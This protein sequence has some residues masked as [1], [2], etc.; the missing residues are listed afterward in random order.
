MFFLLNN[1]V[2]RDTPVN[3]LFSTTEYSKSGPV[4][5]FERDRVANQWTVNFSSMNNAPIGNPFWSNPTLFFNHT[6][7]GIIM[8]SASRVDVIKNT[9]KHHDDRRVESTL[10]SEYNEMAVL[11][12]SRNEGGWWGEF[13]FYR[14]PHRVRPRRARRWR[15]TFHARSREALTSGF[16]VGEFVRDV[17]RVVFAHADDAG[18]VRQSDSRVQVPSDEYDCAD[19]KKKK[20]QKNN[21]R[22]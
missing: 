1:S 8:Y 15:D 11:G 21:K 13:R 14:T 4:V 5:D 6:S 17:D 19:K 22:L 9:S 20:K 10:P 18:L 7:H 12:F 2:W 3:C 16:P